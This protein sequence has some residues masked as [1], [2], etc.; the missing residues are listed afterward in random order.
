MSRPKGSKNKV[1]KASR[2]VR[3]VIGLGKQYI[4][5]IVRDGNIRGK[6][7]ELVVGAES[8]AEALHAAVKWALGYSEKEGIT[9]Y[10]LVK[11]DGV[12]PENRFITRVDCNHAYA[13]NRDYGCWLPILVLEESK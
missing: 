12:V 3:Y 6:V 8:F 9:A 7:A 1:S 5:P 13:A 10:A 11:Y 2:Q 4:F